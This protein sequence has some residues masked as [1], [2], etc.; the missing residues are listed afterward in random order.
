MD[1]KENNP[2]ITTQ[3]NNLKEEPTSFP[4]ILS[5]LIVKESAELYEKNQFEKDDEVKKIRKKTKKPLKEVNNICDS[6]EIDT[7]QKLAEIFEKFQKLVNETK[8]NHEKY[9][10]NKKNYL[11]SREEKEKAKTEN[12][13]VQKST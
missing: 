5:S 13:K 12:Q 6:N 7:N 1:G 3:S 4:D 8:G 9:F 10:S 11:V 2:Q